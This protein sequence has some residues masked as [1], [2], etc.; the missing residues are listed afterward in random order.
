M[1]ENTY[2]PDFEFEE[3]DTVLVRAREHGTSGNIVAKFEATCTDISDPSGIGTSRSARF[4]MP[5][6]T[7]NS[8]TIRP[9]EAEFEVVDE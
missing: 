2:E 7:L 9:Y 5:F 3:G 8:V 4:E 6:G 1:S